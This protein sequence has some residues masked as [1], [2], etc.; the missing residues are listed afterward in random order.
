MATKSP[1]SRSGTSSTTRRA[2]NGA[3]LFTRSPYALAST[4]RDQI[5]QFGALALIEFPTR[6][7]D[8][9]VKVARGEVIPAEVVMA[10]PLPNRLAMGRTER[11]RYFESPAEAA[12]A[13][14]TTEAAAAA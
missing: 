10:W 8:A 12:E 7:G 4:G 13:L 5:G 14:G 1:E 11:V 6:I 3:G 2:S 9:F